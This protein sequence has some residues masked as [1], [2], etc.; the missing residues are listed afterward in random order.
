M[1][2]RTLAWI[3]FGAY[4]V[5]TALLALRGM[6]KTTDL[7]GFALGNG[8]LGPVITGVTLAAAVASTATFV[9]NPGFVYAHGVA[10]LMHLGVASFAGVITGLV[11][12]SR[13]F[14]QLGD[15]GRALTL[16][17]W[18]GNRWQ[19]RGMRTYFAALNLI[20]A[21]TF[22]VLIVKGSALVMQHTL[23]LDY[24]P[25][26]ALIVVFVF[27]YILMGGTYA[28]VY[29][30]ALQGGLMVL[31]ALAIIGSGLHLLGDGLGPFLDRIAA[32]DPN[33]VRLV[34]P[35]SPL[36]DSVWTIYVAG[37]VVGVGLVAQP[38]ILTKSLYLKSE[39]ELGRYLWIA[40]VVCVIYAAVLV[41]GLYAR[42]SLTEVP[43]QDAV[44]PVYLTQAFSPTVGVLVSV[45]LLAAGMSTLDGILVSASTIAANDVFLAVLGDRLM[46]GR[47]KASREAAAFR[48][49][50]WILVAMGLVSFGVALDP[51]RLVGIFAQVGIYG[52]VAASL[53]PIALGV[54]VRGLDARDVM[55]GA[56]VGP[57]VHFAQYGVAVWGL[58]RV[59]NPAVSATSGILASF[60]AVGLCHLIRVARGGAVTVPVTAPEL[61]EQ[62]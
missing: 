29:T 53:A 52:L 39:R 43:K 30:N 12:L 21:I 40:A 55:I 45:A 51:P 46:R 9:I 59:L 11:V 33:L 50:R 34:N 13:G 44:M 23:G 27:S 22:V 26:L 20:L 3:V 4:T 41:A 61:E 19:H 58:G 42:L 56:V 32:Q 47:D 36:F 38:H 24:V 14:R 28:H 6:R 18:V 17:H 60:A 2:A 37:F 25:A 57:V 5:S 1:D 15:R 10:A 8:D 54:L 35:A 49:S 62:T 7:A 31:V 16:P 48:V